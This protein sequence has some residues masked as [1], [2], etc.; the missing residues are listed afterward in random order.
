MIRVCLIV[1][2]CFVSA[3]SKLSEPIEPKKEVVAISFTSNQQTQTVLLSEL[4]WMQ[5]PLPEDAFPITDSVGID[6]KKSIN[7]VLIWNK[8]R[9]KITNSEL[10]ISEIQSSGY[11]DFYV[12]FGME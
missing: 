2:L 5:I 4:D 1:L 3:C 7:D 8:N 6:E 9:P 11:G 10:G 12:H